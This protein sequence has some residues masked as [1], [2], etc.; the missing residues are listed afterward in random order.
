MNYTKDKRRDLAMLP[1]LVNFPALVYIYFMFA[2]FFFQ[3]VHIIYEQSQ[4]GSGFVTK[5]LLHVFSTICLFFILYIEF[6]V[7]IERRDKEGKALFTAAN[8][9]ITILKQYIL[10]TESLY[11][12]S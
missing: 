12:S 10:E 1:R 7:V 6:T 3:V 2:G 5:S 11:M 9:L 4:W 8:I